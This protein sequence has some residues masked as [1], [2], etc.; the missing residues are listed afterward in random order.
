MNQSHVIRLRPIVAVLAGLMSALLITPAYAKK[1]DVEMDTSGISGAAIEQPAPEFPDGKMRGG[2][3]GWVRVSFVI[4]P[5]GRAVDPIV[6]DSSGGPLFEQAALDVVSAWHFEEPGTGKETASNTVEM[7]FEI[8]GDRDRATRNFLRRY[9]DIVSDL[10]YVKPEKARDKVD[11]AND[12]GGWN[13]YES[14]M[15]ALLNARVEAAEGDIA[16]ELEYYR[17]ALAI[18]GP[19]ALD[20]KERV[21][22]LG[23]I[24]ELE[25]D[26]RQFGEARTTLERLRTAPG[27]DAVLSELSGKIR[28]LESAI[29]SDEAMVASGTIY[30]PCNCDSGTPLWAYTPVRRDFSFAEVSGNVDRFEA[31]C[32]NHRLSAQVEA[33]TRWSLPAEWGSCRVFVFGEDAATFDFVEHRE[34]PGDDEVGGSAVASSDVLD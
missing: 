15:L 21:Q 23:R 7:R 3:E 25:I 32:D 4:S 30:N 24:L 1:F 11:M 17:R 19:A 9:R 33:G 31:R 13:L 8:S 28:D 34:N 16:E 22:I 10:Y 18:S 29:D 12:F 14:T 20:R 26:S 27:G 5:D 2:Q 6:V